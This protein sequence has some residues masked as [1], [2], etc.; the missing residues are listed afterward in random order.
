[1]GSFH[2][3]FS[4]CSEGNYFNWQ[5]PSLPDWTEVEQ[6]VKPPV[7]TTAE[8]QEGKHTFLMVAV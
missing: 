5:P 8:L 2:L 4:S 3:L 1:M 6:R 7:L